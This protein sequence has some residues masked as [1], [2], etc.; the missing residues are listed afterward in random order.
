MFNNLPVP[1]NQVDQSTFNGNLPNGNDAVPNIQLSQ[2]MMQNQQIALQAIGYFRAIA[3]STA[4]KS[5]LHAFCYNLLSQNRFQGPVYAQWCQHLMTFVELLII[6][7]GYDSKAGIEMGC[8]RLYEAFLSKAWDEFKNQGLGPNVPNGM[9]AGLDKGLQLFATIMQDNQKYLQGGA[10]A[11]Q[12]Q[13]FNGFNNNNGSFGNNNHGNFTNNTTGNLPRINSATVS[14]SFGSGNAAPV[15][16]PLNGTFNGAQTQTAAGGVYDEPIVEAVK[17]L[18]PVEE[19]SSD[20]YSQYPTEE[21]LPMNNNGNAQQTNANFTQQVQQPAFE[22]TDLPIPLNVDEVIIDPTYYQPAGF[23]LN[24]EDL[25]GVIYNPGGIEIRP[26]H[27]SGWEVT[28]GDEMPY[29]FSIDPST[30]LMFHVRF[31]DGTVK[32]KA[33]EWNEQMNYQRHELDVELRRR[34]QRP[35]GI[36]VEAK[37]PVSS[38]GG[39]VITCTEIKNLQEDGELKIEGPVILG[40]MFSGSTDMEVRAAVQEEMAEL[41]KTEFSATNPMPAV[42][43]VSMKTHYMNLTEDEFN[44]LDEL[45]KCGDLGRVALDLKDLGESGF[46]VSYYRFLSSRLTKSINRFM[47]ENM[48]LSID[49]D[50][51]VTEATD[52]LDYI[53]TKKG[54]KYLEI[55]KKGAHDILRKAISVEQTDGGPCV[56]DYYVNFQLGWFL[57]QLSGMNIHD[58]KPVLVSVATHPVILETLRGMIKRQGPENIDARNLRLITADGA[59]LELI[60]GYLVDKAMLLKLVK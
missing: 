60:R 44:L 37:I 17:P 3:Q 33:I 26:A 56:I 43:Y 58:N 35:N 13:Q 50:D 27:R 47:K 11:F 31:P 59:V 57:D 6:A 52:L 55:I 4:Q 10:A 24:I 20:V 39:E 12:Q 45:S 23:K 40:T 21:Y 49:I 28:L 16:M 18:T 22:E 36:V 8:T 2:Q 42:E 7:K 29:S 41:L 51:F 48:S 15:G 34:S 1:F 53:S 9:W 30:K 46:D 32:E 14:G 54:P 38:I 19:I 5:A 25:Y